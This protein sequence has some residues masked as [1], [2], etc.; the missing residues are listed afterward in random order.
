MRRRSRSVLASAA[1]LSLL[2]GTAACGMSPPNGVRVDRQ[3]VGRLDDEPDVRRLPS[4][5]RPG[6]TPEQ[7][8]RGFLGAAAAVT[9][10]E[11]P[12]GLPVHP[13]LVLFWLILVVLLLIILARS[14]R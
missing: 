7:V 14:L 3:V 1:V 12:F 2:C 10:P 9:E 11:Y 4:G 13:V 6:E 5:P 8:V